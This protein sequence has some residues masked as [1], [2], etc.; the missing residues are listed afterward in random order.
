MIPSSTQSSC[1]GWRK[2]GNMDFI[3]DTKAMSKELIKGKISLKIE[4]KV[5][6]EATVAI[7][8]W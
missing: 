2:C 4:H 3:N 8:K 6:A 1:S 7:N 5:P